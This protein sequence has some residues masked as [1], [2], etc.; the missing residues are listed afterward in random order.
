MTLRPVRLKPSK[1]VF[2]ISITKN[3]YIQNSFQTS[4]LYGMLFELQ[5]KFVIM[6]IKTNT[7]NSLT[8]KKA[9]YLN[10]VF[11]SCFHKA[12]FRFRKIF[13][14]G[15]KQKESKQ[16]LWIFTRPLTSPK[17]RKFP[18]LYFPKSP[19]FTNWVHFVVRISIYKSKNPKNAP[20]SIPIMLV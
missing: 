18:M 15:H 2:S 19:D 7:P 17:P 6:L 14:Y 1:T 4:A 13:S 9:V 12:L 20:N 11:F 5:N 10:Q 3:I 16:F 8:V